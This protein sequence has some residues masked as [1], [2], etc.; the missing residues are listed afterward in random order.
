MSTLLIVIIIVVLIIAMSTVYYVRHRQPT[1]APTSNTTS[2]AS[3]ANFKT[4]LANLSSE[5]FTFASSP[6]P[7]G[8]QYNTD[9]ETAEIPQVAQEAQIEEPRRNRVAADALLKD[10]SRIQK[11]LVADLINRAKVAMDMLVPPESQHLCFPEPKNAD[12]V[13][14]NIGAVIYDSMQAQADLSNWTYTASIASLMLIRYSIIAA[15]EDK[16]DLI[17]VVKNTDGDVVSVILRPKM[18][19]LLAN[20]VDRVF[21]R[22]F[23]L[24]TPMKNFVDKYQI[25][26]EMHFGINMQEVKA[27]SRGSRKDAA[28]KNAQKQA[29]MSLAGRTIPIVPFAAAMVLLAANEVT[30][31]CEIPSDEV[32]L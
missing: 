1:L 30:S 31:K 8:R 18:A 28:T 21:D 4:V 5:T 17:T 27:T 13:L 15:A 32:V 19:R 23:E 29:F 20:M 25:M 2:A 14:Q 22:Y 26:L 16:R 7:G 3:I 10:T 6:Y 9:N 24:S 12:E 11:P